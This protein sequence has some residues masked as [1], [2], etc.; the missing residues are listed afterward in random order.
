MNNPEDML[1]ACPVRQ[2]AQAVLDRMSDTFTAR[3]GRKVS[4]EGDDG[5]K[6]WIVHSD[7]IEDLRR[8]LSR[9][10]VEAS[11]VVERVQ[12]VRQKQKYGC[13]AAV[14]AMVLGTTYEEAAAKLATDPALFDES[15]SGYHVLE[16][17]LVQHGF[18]ISRKWRVYQPGNQ[19]RDQWPCEPFADLHWC[20]VIADGGFGH[21]VLLLRDGTVLDPMSD[22]PKRL[23]DYSEVNFVAALVPLAPPLG[24]DWAD[25][26][27]DLAEAISDSLD[28]DWSSRDGARACVK[29]LKDRAALAAIPATGLVEP[30]EAMIEAGYAVMSQS[31]SE[32]GCDY[33]TLLGRAY[34]AMQSAAPMSARTASSTWSIDCLRARKLPNES[35]SITV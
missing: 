24:P 3:N 15:G 35:L 30:S 4:I 23:T 20:E 5:E 32:A 17:Q 18:A 25:L 27:D 11:E 2:A 14:L 33:K 10:P 8:A 26:E 7:D 6:C 34:R 29:M 1:K 21:A 19:K 13:T 31:A 28:Y 9:P 22:E 12:L 16:S